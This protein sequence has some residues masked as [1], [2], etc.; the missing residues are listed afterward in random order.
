MNQYSSVTDDNNSAAKF[1]CLSI[2][3]MLEWYRSS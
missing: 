1:I 2:C 3:Y